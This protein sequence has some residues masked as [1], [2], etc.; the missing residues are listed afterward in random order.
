MHLNKGKKNVIHPGCFKKV[1]SNKY[2]HKTICHIKKN[3]ILYNKV[4]E[5]YSPFSNPESLMS[6]ETFVKTIH[7]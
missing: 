4:R 2:L 7:L 6:P 5:H 3:F 1:K